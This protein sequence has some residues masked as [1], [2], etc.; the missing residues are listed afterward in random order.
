MIFELQILG[1]NS[2][3]FAYGR[4][5]T[6]QLLKLNNDSF[7]IDCGEATQLRLQHFRVK[8][9]RIS[10]IFISHLHGDH[11]LGLPG[12]LQSLNIQGRTTPLQV[13]G[14][15]GLLE[16]LTTINKFSATVINFPLEIIE[17]DTSVIKPIF[18]S[19]FVKVYTIPMDHRIPC[20]GYLFEEVVKRRNVK[21]DSLPYGITPDEI[22][23]L[24]NGDHVLHPDGRIKFS[25]DTYT[26]PPRKGRK[27]AYCSDTKYSEQIVPIIKEVDMLY[28]EATFAEDFADRAAETYHSTA[29]E[30]GRIAKLGEVGKLIIGH[31]SSRYAE[32]SRLLQEARSVFP[33]TYLA[34]EGETFVPGR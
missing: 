30:A 23:T 29:R 11:F 10:K 19:D 34:E 16:I 18:T 9:G 1:S 28:H 24:K 32:P 12:L 22:L 8:T 4:H 33:A 7:L 26:W 6:S 2:A 5:H 20:C 31:F 17:V 27:Y 25:V 3:S 14:P 15:K 21:S 13:Y